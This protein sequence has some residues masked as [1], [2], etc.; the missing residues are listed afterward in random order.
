MKE[1]KT[2]DDILQFAMNEEQKAVDFYTHLAAQSNNEDMK[3]VFE[4]FAKEEV[5]HKAR[6]SRIREQGSYTMSEQQ[7]ADL[8]IADYKTDVEPSADLDYESAL[9]V[10]M[11][12]EKAAFRLYT[13]LAAHAP[14]KEMKQLFHSLA[15]EESKHKLRFEMEYD[16]NVLREN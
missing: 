2:I 3:K 12:K 10:A 11:K 8:K 7:V 9:V 1:F 4:S 15:L 6:L 14:N 13:D 16:D 5:G